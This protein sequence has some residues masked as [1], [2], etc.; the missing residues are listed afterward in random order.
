[1]L[2]VRA[3]VRVNP[4][5]ASTTESVPTLRANLLRPVSFNR[6]GRSR[7]IVDQLERRI[8]HQKSWRLSHDSC[9]FSQTRFLLG[10]ELNFHS[11]SVAVA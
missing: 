2:M 9:D 4:I 1:M 5:P 11:K 8:L 3:P 6:P 7:I 10:R